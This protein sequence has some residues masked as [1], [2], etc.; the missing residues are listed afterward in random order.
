MRNKA[1]KVKNLNEANETMREI[2]FLQ[3][4]LDRIDSHADRK[5]VKLKEQASIEGENFR[6]QLIELEQALS[7]YAEYNKKELFVEKRS[8]DLSFGKIGFHK[9]TS[10]SI[11]NKPT[12]KSTLA[13]L[14][15]TLS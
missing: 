8:V 3:N 4:E 10:I 15:K 2:A 9:S 14:K 11:K 1:I 12:E 5:I 13:L 6:K 7:V